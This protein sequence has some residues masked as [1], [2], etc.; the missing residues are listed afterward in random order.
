MPKGLAAHLQAGSIQHD[1]FHAATAVVAFAGSRQER[2]N[3]ATGGI[4]EPCA[5]GTPIRMDVG[6]IV[7]FGEHLAG[8]GLGTEVDHILHLLPGSH[9]GSIAALT[10]LTGA[11]INLIVPV[12]VFPQTVSCEGSELMP[13]Q[14]C[15]AAEINECF[16]VRFREVSIPNGIAP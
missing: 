5:I 13:S 6:G 16:V 3:G 9:D 4:V 2:R 8:S 1:P 15:G 12:L 11:N 14:A 10:T 7:Y